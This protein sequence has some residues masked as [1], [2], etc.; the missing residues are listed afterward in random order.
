MLS[1]LIILGKGIIMLYKLTSL[2]LE[3]KIY[4]KWYYIMSSRLCH[5]GLFLIFYNKYKLPMFKVL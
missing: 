1:V 5:L 4:C 2:R 3:N